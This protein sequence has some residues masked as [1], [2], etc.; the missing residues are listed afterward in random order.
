MKAV[1]IVHNVAIDGEVDEALEALGIHCFTKFTDTLGRGQMSEPHL[2]T[3]VWPGT[4]L[5]TLV[6]VEDL[7]AKAVMSRVRQLRQTLGKEGVKAF[8]WTIEETT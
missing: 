5:A 1:L 7:Q 2:N 6:V 4:N 3:D 8:M